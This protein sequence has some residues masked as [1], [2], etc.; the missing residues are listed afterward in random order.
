MRP[1]TNRLVGFESDVKSTNEMVEMERTE[2]MK[3]R[4]VVLF[5]VLNFC[6]T[7]FVQKQR[8]ARD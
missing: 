8:G 6:V 5:V 1:V 2:Q 7:F 3:E 4:A